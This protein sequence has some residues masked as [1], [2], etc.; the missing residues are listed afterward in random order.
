[1]LDIE[2][3]P[4]TIEE[5]RARRREI[6]AIATRHGVRSLL[7]FGSVARDEARSDSD[8]DLLVELEPDRTVLDLS[9]LIL[10]LMEVLGRSVHVVEIDRASRFRDKMLAEAVPL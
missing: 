7:V 5:L 8:V 6:W 4:P 2:P 3:S 9:R 10:D 1:M